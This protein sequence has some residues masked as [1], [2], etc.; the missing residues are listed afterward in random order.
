MSNTEKVWYG[1]NL[2]SARLGAEALYA[3]DDF[4]APISR[5]IQDH[6]PVWVDDKYDD[7]GKWMDGWESRRKRA[8][9]FDYGIIK[10][11]ISGKIKTLEIDTRFFTGNF[12][13]ATLIEA[14]YSETTPDENTQWTEITENI[15]LSGN[16]QLFVDVKDDTVYNF[17]RVNIYPDG[18]IARLRVYG[19]P[20]VRWDDVTGDKQID[21]VA[22][23]NGGRALAC[24]DEHFG[25]M[26]NIIMPGKGINMGDGWET[27]RR[28]EP[29]ND[30]VILALGHPGEVESVVIDTA[31]FK[32]NFPDGLSLQ[33]ANISDLPD[34]TLAAQSIYWKEL[35]PKQSLSA[36]AEH[37]F[38]EQLNNVGVITH[39]RMNIFPDG[40][41]SRI[42]LMGK[43]VK[44]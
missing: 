12:A 37:S 36:D 24:N 2:A 35:L 28:R 7:N 1:V 11:G 10:L 15:A 30:W 29:G 43:P 39:V 9:G 14:C 34:S 25:T 13:P 18:G 6:D 5:M 20:E 21:L 40:G 17:I 3:T 33:V 22:V 26:H 32:G 27:R 42:R 38:T 4:F 16:N 31:F 8:E 44:N 19:E 41:V 23:E